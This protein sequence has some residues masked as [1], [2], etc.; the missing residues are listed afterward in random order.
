MST[1]GVLTKA[2]RC[3]MTTTARA[4]GL[5][6]EAAWGLTHLWIYPWGMGHEHVR[7]EGAYENHRTDRLPL[8]QRG[9]IVRDVDAS[10]VPVL[11]VHGIG[12]N[13]SIFAVLVRV[14]RRRGYGVV[15]AVNFSVLTPVT[16][17]IRAAARD[18]AHHVERLR[19]RTG[20]DAVHIVGH[21]LGGLIARYYVQRLG[22]DDA[23]ET[24]VTMGTAHPGQRVGDGAAPHPSRAT[25]ASRVRPARRAGRTGAGL[26]YEVPGRLEPPRP[27]DGAPQQRP[28]RPSRPDRGTP[29]ARPCRAPVDGH[30][31][32][33][34]APCR[35]VAGPPRPCRGAGAAPPS[36]DLSPRFLSQVVD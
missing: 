20:S 23:V 17:D 28:A 2:A 9:L 34:P 21:S 11:L 30:R 4:W 35:R 24:L 33:H 16:G 18:L 8:S 15:H 3:P 36:G 31:P 1:L 19:M 26:P 13:R 10:T 27:D 25:A 6:V 14:L 32:P 22:G 29:R 12:D 7:A 5:A